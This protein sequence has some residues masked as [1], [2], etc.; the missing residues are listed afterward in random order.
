MFSYNVLKPH[1]SI[2]QQSLTLKSDIIAQLLC[3]LDCVPSVSHSL[4]REINTSAGSCLL[5]PK[6]ALTSPLHQPQPSS[7]FL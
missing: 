5:C 6:Y 1:K 3:I 2:M 4:E 7:Q